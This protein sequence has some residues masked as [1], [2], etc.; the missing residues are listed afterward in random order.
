MDARRVYFVTRQNHTRTF[1]HA[2]GLHQL[3]FNIKSIQYGF[4]TGVYCRYCWRHYVCTLLSLTLSRMYQYLILWDKFRPINRP[5]NIPW[6]LSD[7]A[8]IPTISCS[9]YSVHI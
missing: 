1:I 4:S 2:L 3:Q 6:C 5:K 9:S 8:V 7:A